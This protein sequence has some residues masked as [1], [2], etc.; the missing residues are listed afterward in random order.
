VV[1]GA[2]CGGLRC[3]L[4]WSVVHS[5][6]VCGA[7]CGGL[8]CVLRWY[9]VCGAVCGGLRFSDL[10]ELSASCSSLLYALRVLVR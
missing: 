8:R 2:V 3:V 4:R 10:P 9:V 7:F 5:A 1:C 6:V